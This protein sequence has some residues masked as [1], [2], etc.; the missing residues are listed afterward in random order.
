MND[1]DLKKLISLVKDCLTWSKKYWDR[2]QQFGEE[3]YTQQDINEAFNNWN[4]AEKDLKDFISKI[5]TN[6]TNNTMDSEKKFTRIT[7]ESSHGVKTVLDFNTEDL[8]A[9]DYIQAMVTI[10]TSATFTPITIYRVMYEC[11]KDALKALGDKE[12]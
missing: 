7:H 6:K 5:E 8:G 12:V 2:S 9:E 4:W 10:M 3:E 11:S 1:N